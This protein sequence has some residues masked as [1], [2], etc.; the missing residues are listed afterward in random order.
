MSCSLLRLRKAALA[1]SLSL[2]SLSSVWAQSPADKDPESV[3][4]DQPIK[5]AENVY[6]AIGATQYY[7]YDNGGHNNNLSFVIGNES[8][9]VVNGGA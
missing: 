4:Y 6:S 8:V 5:V 1:F 2:F 9:L 3:L 7:S